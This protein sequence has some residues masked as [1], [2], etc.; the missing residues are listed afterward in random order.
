[1]IDPKQYPL[2]E[3]LVDKLVHKFNN[4]GWITL[5]NE[6]IFSCLVNDEVADKSM[7]YDEWDT[8]HSQIGTIINEQLDGTFISY[9]R[10]GNDKL[11]PIVMY[12]ENEGRW[13]EEAFL[14]E[15]FV[16]YFKL[17]KEAK[18][19]NEYVYYQVDE[20]G[21]DVEVARV[22]GLNLDVKLKYIKEYI[23]VKKLNLLVF[24]DEVINS[25]KSIDELGGN[26]IQMK[27]IQE[28]DCIF[29][30]SLIESLGFG[31]GYKSS[32][33]FRG[34]CILRHNDKDIQHLW[35][36]R[37]SGYED[38]VIGAD[39]DGKEVL[40]QICLQGKVTNPIHCL[41]FFLKEMFC[42]DIFKQ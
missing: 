24:I 1:M 9:S 29:S 16:M 2:C 11:E 39:E 32:A 19:K 31:H 13:E 22:K 7:T 42:Q 23:A 3:P 34:K 14:A 15:E 26:Q 28:N 8:N 25:N 20:C 5:C 27:K 6:R 33:V 18:G 30:Y 17:H 10:Y 35:K 21:D 40:C 36:L 41:L 37:D 38:F 12:L 4:G